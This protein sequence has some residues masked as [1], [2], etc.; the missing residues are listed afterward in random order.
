MTHP[1][2]A[3]VRAVSVCPVTSPFCTRNLQFHF[4]RLYITLVQQLQN[5][6][7]P[8]KTAYQSAASRTYGRQQTPDAR[9]AGEVEARRGVGTVQVPGQWIRSTGAQHAMG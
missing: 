3:L 5:T 4:V 6:N 2:T 1:K 8:Y 7:T 9:P